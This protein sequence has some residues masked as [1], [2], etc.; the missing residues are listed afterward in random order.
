MAS[1][2]RQSDINYSIWAARENT[3]EQL[4]ELSLNSE[5]LRIS[6][7][8]LQ[9]WSAPPAKP[10]SFSPGRPQLYPTQCGISALFVCSGSLSAQCLTT[11]IAHRVQMHLVWEFQ[12]TSTSA[13]HFTSQLTSCLEC[14]QIGY[15]YWCLCVN[16][17]IYN[18]NMMEKQI[19]NWKNR[20]NWLVRTSFIFT[21][22]K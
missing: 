19:F 21:T 12:H 5:E 18:H 11:V 10:T 14:S 7:F 3:F 9:P 4:P 15:Y 1:F 20:S 16:G 2:T 6:P 17:E 13:L 8:S 22:E